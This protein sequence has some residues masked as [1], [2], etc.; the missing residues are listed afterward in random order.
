[1]ESVGN[2]KRIQALFR[3]MKLADERL[4]PEF[5]KVWNRAQAPS[6][7]SPRV[8]KISFA[9]ATAALLVITLS[10]L[11]LWSRNE[12]P[13]D[14]VDP[15]VATELTP[16]GSM[17]GSTPA[18]HQA[19]PATSPSTRPVR[20]VVVQ[21]PV[22]VKSNQWPPKLAARRKADL[23]ARNAVIREAVSISSWQSPTA[24]LMQSPADHVLTSLPQLDRSLNELKTFLPNTLQ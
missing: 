19:T 22:R 2:E 21:S 16:P 3:E 9:V 15:K 7:G 8:F 20:S 5:I 11:V 23:E 14:Q 4:A 10:A 17:P 24:T 18:P 13:G 1:M 12:Q 6:P